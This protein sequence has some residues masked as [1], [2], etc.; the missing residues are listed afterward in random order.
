MADHSPT[1][2]VE[3]GAQMDYAE[4]DRTY[5]AF[6][7]LAKYGSL[8]CAAILIAMAFGFFVGG[9]FSATILFILIM[10]VGALILR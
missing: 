4:H 5:K 2:P 3:L 8:V 7:G 6:L 9:F 10:A 1:G